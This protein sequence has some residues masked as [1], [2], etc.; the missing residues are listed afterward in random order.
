MNDSISKVIALSSAM[1]RM[2]EMRGRPVQSSI[3]RDPIP[4]PLRIVGDGPADNMTAVHTEHMLA[5]NAEHYDFWAA[6]TGADRDAWKWAWWGEN[7]T[8]TGINEETLRVGDIVRIGTAEFRVTSP[9]IPCFKVA[10]RI[11]QP[12]TILPRMMETGKVG[13]HL[14]VLRPGE[15]SIDDRIEVESPEPD[16]ITL[17]ELSR[18]L[19]SLSPD[20]LPELK[21][22]MDIPALGSK[23][24]KT[25]RQRITLIEDRE[26]MR[27][28]R[29]RGWKPFTVTAIADEAAAIRSFYLK[30][31]DDEPL[32]PPAAGQFLTV[33]TERDGETEIV[34]PWT[35]SGTDLDARHYR[36]TIK[37]I[38]GGAGSA[39][40]HQH[41]AVGDTVFARP[42]A[43]QFV[44]DRSGFRRIGLVS[45]GIGA[46]PMLPMLIAH[47]ERGDNAPPLIWLQV[48]KNG[49]HHPFRDEVARLL[50]QVPKLE[51]HIFYTQPSADDRAG[52]DYDHVGRPTVEQVAA[53]TGAVYPIN[54]FGREVPMPG[55]ETE[56]YICGPQEFEALMRAGLGQIGVKAE[57]VK[58]EAFVAASAAPGEA[59]ATGI[60]RAVVRFTESGLTAEWHADDGLTLLDLAEAVGLSPLYACRT[61]VC[62]SCQ[63]PLKSGEIGY[64]PIPPIM[65]ESGQ[66]LVCCARPAS[67]EIE[68]AL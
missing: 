58:S 44:L 45:A 51:R 12:D 38:E 65:P 2:V 31:Q 41:I 26:R 28:G 9:R 48:V 37:E 30:P 3:V 50:A 29:W 55:K 8:I 61:G 32:A 6:E 54:P 35:I 40:M 52:I 14:E 11:D 46:T 13:I 20:V 18:L 10:W 68:I 19:L 1:P 4:G 64:S 23:A 60:E 33:R 15:V 56:F 43:G 22:A 47:I 24:A 16:N 27:I 63:C 5:F 59:I 53:L 66:V 57:A 49:S 67:A 34:R 21:R 39:R 62:Q 7:L 17:A 36:L 42:P 25:V